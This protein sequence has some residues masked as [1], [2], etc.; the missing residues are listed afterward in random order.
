MAFNPFHR[1]RKH[2]KVI[3]AVLTILIMFVFVLSTGTRGDFFTDVLPRFFGGA[4]KNQGP[5]V[6][7]VYGSKLYEKELLDQ[8]RKQQMASVLVGAL[9]NAAVNA[10]VSDAV[11]LKADKDSDL[12]KVIT[13][14][15]NR[16]DSRGQTDPAE[17]L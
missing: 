14:V 15:Q 9:T 2:Q 17:D 7:T 16:R 3:F 1:F 10:V 4:G 8:G 11:A 13:N 12:A 6:A 5:Y